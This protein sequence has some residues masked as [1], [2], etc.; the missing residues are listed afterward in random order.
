MD[1][2]ATNN[3]RWMVIVNPN[4]GTG[5]GKKDWSQI[6]F[7]LSHYNLEFDHRF[8]ETKG[9]AVSLASEAVRNGYRKLITV[10]GDG[11]L[12]EVINGIFMNG[13]CRPGEVSLGIVPV[14]TGNDWGKMFGI[15]DDYATAVRI[16]TENKTL[17]HD[18]GLIEFM[19]GDEWKSRYFINIAGF[20]FESAVVKRTNRQKDKGRS[21]KLIYL[22]S[23]LAAMFT[24]RN[25]R[26]YIRVDSQEI[27]TDIFSI[28]IG[29]GRY[30]GGGMQQ[31]PEALPDDG[32]LDVTVIKNMNKLEIIRN[33]KILY[34]GKILSHPKITGY[35]CR[36]IEVSSDQVVWAEADGEFLGHTPARVTVLPGM[37]RMI[38]G[39]RLIP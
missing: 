9:H 19:D 4:A 34:N 39:T 17:L 30:C 25:A 38:Y 36:E 7:L 15:P 37:I 32:F 24:Y 22:F 33:L 28:N 13:E 20:G 12:N 16:I 14:G 31:T 5:R 27:S 1:D 26:T 8:T 2:L 21:G 11:T 18:T 10:G 35:R 3:T 6:A 23:L 29:N